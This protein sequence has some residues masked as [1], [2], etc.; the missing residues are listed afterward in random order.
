MCGTDGQMWQK[1]GAAHRP[2]LSPGGGGNHFA[3]LTVALIWT[4]TDCPLRL[5]GW[6]SD[7]TSRVF[8]LV[9]SGGFGLPF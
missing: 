5:M 3:T 7:T 4:L 9:D 1:K 6:R 8:S 2:A